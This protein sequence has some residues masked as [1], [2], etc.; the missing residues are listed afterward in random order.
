MCG[1]QKR[2]DTEDMANQEETRSKQ[3]KANER[4][5]RASEAVEMAAGA[6]RK[7]IAK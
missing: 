5:S 2:S 7:Q 4:M 6:P 3:A 1:R